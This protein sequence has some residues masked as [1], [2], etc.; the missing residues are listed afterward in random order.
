MNDQIQGMKII[1]G[2]TAEGMSSTL[3]R[4]GAMSE[5]SNQLQEQGARTQAS[6][7]VVF[8]KGASSDLLAGLML[9]I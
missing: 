4:V 8:D 1:T 7:R 6:Q 5:F 2:T 9:R 3:G